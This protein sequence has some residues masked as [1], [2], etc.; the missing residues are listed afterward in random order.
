MVEQ[1]TSFRAEDGKLFPD[2]FEAVE[3]DC[4]MKLLN[5]VGPTVTSEIMRKKL[6]VH[7]AL[8]PLVDLLS[9]Q[10]TVASNA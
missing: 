8:T 6:A 2:E 4:R 9:K 3:Y 1:V 7:A 5:C 10:P